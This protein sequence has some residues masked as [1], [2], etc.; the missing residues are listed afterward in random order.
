[1][2]TQEAVGVRHRHEPRGRRRRGK[3]RS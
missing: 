2:A 3:D 1:M